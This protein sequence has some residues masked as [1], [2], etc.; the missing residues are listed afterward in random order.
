MENQELIVCQAYCKKCHSILFLYPMAKQEQ[1]ITV[2][3]NC[4]NVT[5]CL[6]TNKNNTL[7]WKHKVADDENY[8]NLNVIL[9]ESETVIGTA[10]TDIFKSI[11]NLQKAMWRFRV[12]GKPG[13][14]QAVH[15]IINQLLEIHIDKKHHFHI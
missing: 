8:L 11:Q 4:G 7:T 6:V 3:C 15:D 14:A 2:K 12:K 13:K 9:G 1:E 10:T 5:I